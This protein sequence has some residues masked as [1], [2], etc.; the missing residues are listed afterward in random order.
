MHTSAGWTPWHGHCWPPRRSSNRASSTR[1]A[2]LVMPDGPTSW[3][4]RSWRTRRFGISTR[5][6]CRPASRPGRPGTRR[7]WRTW[8]RGTSSEPA[9][10]TARGRAAR[11]LL[12][13]TIR[14]VGRRPIAEVVVAAA[15]L[16]SCD[17]QLEQPSGTLPPLVTVARST[18]VAPITATAA[19]EPSTAPTTPT[20]ATSAATEFPTTAP[21]TT[22]PPTTAPPTT[23]PP[24]ST[25]PT[26]TTAVV[27]GALRYQVVRGDTLFGIARAFR[28][29]FAAIQAVNDPATLAV[30]H[31]HDTIVLPAGATRLRSADVATTAYVVQ[32]GDTIMTI[33]KAHKTTPAELLAIN[34]KL[35]T[36]DVLR[37][38]ERLLIPSV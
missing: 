30:I 11:V 36:P 9:D 10:S 6:R 35:K 31:P 16:A 29:S 28:T 18:T 22:A 13:S 23:S 1:F 17:S 4:S 25:L 34:N 38:G 37:V 20:P 21:P 7:C 19:T 12:T 8:W 15:L 3:A 26:P 32:A 24:S 33:A 14:R 5:E 2:R 27:P